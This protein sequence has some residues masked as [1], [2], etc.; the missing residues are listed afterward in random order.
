MKCAEAPSTSTLRSQRRCPS[1]NLTN[2]R[3]SLLRLWLPYRVSLIHHRGRPVFPAGKPTNKT[4]HPPLPRFFPLQ[5]FPSRV[6]PHTSDDSQ[7]VGYV[8]SSGFRTLSTLCSPHDL[9]N[10]FHPGP[11]LGVHSSRPSSPRNAVRRFRRR[12]PHEVPPVPK[13][14]SAP[15][16]VQHATRSPPTTPGD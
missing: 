8:A 5:R 4:Q 9:P 12:A 10:L 13:N 7:I 15:P 6:E 3:K 14:Q 16:G 11:V 2:R 1:P